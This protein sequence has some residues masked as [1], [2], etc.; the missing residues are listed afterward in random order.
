LLYCCEKIIVAI[1][2]RSRSRP[3]GWWPG[4]PSE[5]KVGMFRAARV[6]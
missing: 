4:G 6:T 3:S 5:K 2:G 1:K